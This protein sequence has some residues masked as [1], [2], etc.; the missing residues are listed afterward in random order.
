MRRRKLLGLLAAAPAIARSAAAQSDDWNKVV[1]AARKEGKLAF[2][3]A[4]IGSPFHKQVFDAFE[5][6]YGIKVE[7]LEARASEVSP[8]WE[9]S[10][11]AAAKRMCSISTKVFAAMGFG[12]GFLRESMVCCGPGLGAA[13]FGS[14]ICVRLRSSWAMPRRSHKRRNEPAASRFSTDS[15]GLP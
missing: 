5:K 10:A 12:G 2:Y 6:K 14:S 1:D 3:T 4:S 9:E 15:G 8:S 11:A 13:T 7:L